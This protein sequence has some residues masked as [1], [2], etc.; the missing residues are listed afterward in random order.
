MDDLLYL[1]KENKELIKYFKE[2]IDLI[3]HNSTTDSEELWNAGKKMI[4][5]KFVGVF[6][7]DIQP[8]LNVGECMILNNETSKQSGEHWISLV[9][10]DDITYL[11]FDSYGNKYIKIIPNLK[12]TIHKKNKDNK[13]INI[14]SCKTVRQHG[15]QQYCG[16]ISLAWLKYYYSQPV[17]LMASVI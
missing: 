10:Y 7:Y 11:F 17:G 3:G 12:S 8:K 9:R 2:A 1:K 5:K 14:I 6:P 4:G 13:D 16:Q 15:F